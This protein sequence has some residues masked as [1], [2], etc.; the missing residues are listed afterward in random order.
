MPGVGLAGG[1]EAR[2]SYDPWGVQLSGPS[3]EMGY[4]GAWERPTDPTSD[5]IQMGARTYDPSLGGFLSEDPVF[6]H[7]GIG[8]SVDRY[9]YVRDNPLNY[10]DLNGRETCV[11]T[12]VGSVCP[13][14]GIEDI[15]GGAGL[16]W[17]GIEEAGNGVG[18]SAGHAW[19]WTAPS[20]SWVANQ[21]QDF[22]KQYGTTLE[23]LY[24]FA[25][26]NWQT[27]IEGGSAGAAAGFVLGTPAPVIGNTAGAAIGGVGGCAG[28]VGAKV[29]ISSL[30]E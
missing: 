12:P 27:C 5:L 18:S 9:L 28:L 30:G 2:Q 15:G 3:L 6:G 7:L 11:S 29:G 13:V 4:L 26:E 25:G 16:A 24:R 1:M 10:Y 20:R 14:K 19:N 23:G 8:A 21:A 22:W 17:H